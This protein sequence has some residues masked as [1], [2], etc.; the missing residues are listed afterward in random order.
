MAVSVVTPK[1]G[2]SRPRQK[3]STVAP[4]TKMAML[5]KMLADQQFIRKARQNGMS[6][7]ELREKHGFHFKT[8]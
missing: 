1:H 7:K 6:F 3:K 5:Q 8:V 2:G 4:M